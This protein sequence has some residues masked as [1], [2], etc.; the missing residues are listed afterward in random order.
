MTTTAPLAFERTARKG[1]MFWAML[2]VGA[3]FLF[4]GNTVDPQKNCDETGKECAPWLVPLAAGAGWLIVAAALGQLWVNPRR[5]YSIDAQTGDLVWWTNRTSRTQGD[6]GRIHPSQIVSV[7]IIENDDSTTLSLIGQD[8][9][10]LAYF[11][12][13]LVPWPCDSWAETFQ[14]AHPHIRIDKKR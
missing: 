1:V 4:A 2:L 3:A 5:G 6:M 9:E 12:E 11:D 7:K 13:E 10:R 14:R 8:G